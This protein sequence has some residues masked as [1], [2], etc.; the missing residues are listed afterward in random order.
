MVAAPAPEEILLLR[1]W[2]EGNHAPCRNPFRLCRWNARSVARFPERAW[3][4]VAERARGRPL[5]LGLSTSH[6]SPLL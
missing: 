1:S 4:R 2:N 6:S 3:E 5:Q